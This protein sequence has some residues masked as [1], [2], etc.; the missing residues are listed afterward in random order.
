LRPGKLISLW[1]NG[2]TQPHRVT[3]VTRPKGGSGR[4]SASKGMGSGRWAVKD[5]NL[6]PLEQRGGT[7]WFPRDPPPYRVDA[8]VGPPG[9]QSRPPAAIR[10]ASSDRHLE[11]PRYPFGPPG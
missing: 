4:L 7:P 5:L 6:R 11:S 1:R 2:L 9:R 3:P 10:G 8:V